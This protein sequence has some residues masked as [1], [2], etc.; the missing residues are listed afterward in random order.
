MDSEQSEKNVD[1]DYAFRGQS[2]NESEEVASSDAGLD[3]L[4]ASSSEDFVTEDSSINSTV[5]NKT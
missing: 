1:E 3:E 5:S 4:N 2:D